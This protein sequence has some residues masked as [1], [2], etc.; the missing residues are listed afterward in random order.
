MK[1]KLFLGIDTSNYT[2]SVA[3]VDIDGRCLA[4]IKKPLPVKEGSCGLRQSDAVFFHTV[5]LPEALRAAE[6]KLGGDAPVAIGVSEKPRNVQGS[7]MPCFLSG[8]AAATAASVASGATLYRFSHQCGHLMAA[9]DSSGRD[10]L[11]ETTFGAFHV[12]GGTT[13][14]VRARFDGAS[15]ITE[16]VGGTKD[17]NAGQAID[18]IGVMMGLPFPA[19]PSMER[20]A[21]QNKTRLPPRKLS[22]EGTAVHLSGLENI[23][24]RLYRETN[25]K[26]LVAAFTLTFIAESL[27]AMSQAYKDT[28]GAQPILYAGGV[29]SNGLIKNHICGKFDAAF[30]EPAFSADNAVGIALLARHTFLQA[31]ENA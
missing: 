7:Y 2:T 13:E 25:D 26:P 8:V 12:S 31:E 23:A 29:M 16:L 11:K 24:A 3:V 27:A 15:F 20:L 19:G 30:A 10:D 18:R 22:V 9:L 1:N 6:E 14:L 21:A 17:L 5:N 28:Y 4:N